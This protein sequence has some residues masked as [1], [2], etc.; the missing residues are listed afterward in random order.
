MLFLALSVLSQAI[1]CTADFGRDLTERIWN[2]D[3]VHGVL[4]YVIEYTVDM[5]EK[6]KYRTFELNPNKD[7]PGNIII[8]LDDSCTMEHT[9]AL[10]A[11]HYSLEYMRNAV[12]IML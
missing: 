12:A 9:P 10:I 11:I 1:D 7:S 6:Q 2:L 5:C 8:L 3:H 4:L